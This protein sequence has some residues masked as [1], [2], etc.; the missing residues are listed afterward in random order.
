MHIESLKKHG[1]NITLRGK[2]KTVGAASDSVIMILTNLLPT[3]DLCGPPWVQ[4]S[5]STHRC[6]T[7]NGQPP[8]CAA[9]SMMTSRHLVDLLS[10][11]PSSSKFTVLH[12]SLIFHPKQLQL[13]LLYQLDY[14]GMTSLLYFSYSCQQ[15]SILSCNSTGLQSAYNNEQ[16]QQRQ[17]LLQQNNKLQDIKYDKYGQ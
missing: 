10:P 11:F 13:F 17:Q 8:K 6:W 16:Q 1:I 12:W 15:L 5:S 4:W 9:Q 3:R 14:G 2:I 7:P